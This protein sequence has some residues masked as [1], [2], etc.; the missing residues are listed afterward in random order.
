[1]YLGVGAGGAE[2]QFMLKSCNLCIILALN[3]T[4][5][6]PG[7]RA[8]HCI[9]ALGQCDLSWQQSTFLDVDILALNS[10]RAASKMEYTGIRA[11]QPIRALGQKRISGQTSKTAYPGSRAKGLSRHLCSIPAFALYPGTHVL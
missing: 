2:G 1:M 7:T 9:R 5:M 3:G 4:A 8:E 6:Y 11:V 10:I